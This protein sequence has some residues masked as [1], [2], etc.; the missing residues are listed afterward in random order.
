MRYDQ[1]VQQGHMSQ[2]YTH[3][4]CG[5]RL[6]V[7]QGLADADSGAYTKWKQACWSVSVASGRGKLPNMVLRG[8]P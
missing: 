2:Q 4:Q 6:H 1:H 5:A 7:C 3:Q 8:L